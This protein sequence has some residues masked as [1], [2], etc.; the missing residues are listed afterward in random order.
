MRHLFLA[1]PLLFAPVLA[2]AEACRAGVVVRLVG[3]VSLARK[4]GLFPPFTGLQ[5]CQGDRFVTGPA[6]IAELRLRDG[7][8]ITLGRDSEFVI[9]EYRLY[10]D[11]PNVATFDLVKGAFRSITGLITRRAS[12]YVVHSRVAT[13]GV[14]GTD[15]WGGYGLTENGFDVVMLE[16]HGVY[17]DSATGGHVELYQSGQGTTVMNGAAPAAATIWGEDKVRRAFATITP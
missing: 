16:G 2:H 3:E 14:R 11:R 1:L 9:R 6:S 4:T 17:V 7:T 15:F 12:R 5:I 8:L 10:R 13:I